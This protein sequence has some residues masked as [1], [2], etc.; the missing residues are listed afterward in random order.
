MEM[1]EI[2]PTEINENFIKLIGAD[3]MLVTAGDIHDFNMMTAS[4]GG[5]GVLWGLPV[6]TA[7]VRPER[8]TKGYIDRT[9]RFTLTFYPESMRK[10]LGVMGKESGRTFDKMHYPGLTP[11]ALSSG[12][13]AFAEA[14]LVIDCEVKYVDSIKPEC[15][16]DKGVLRW[17]GAAQGGYH[18]MY[19]AEIK[20]VYVAQ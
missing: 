2:K 18:D 3:W 6:A 5:V 1:K 7:Y 11:V 8:F 14:R 4:W 15:M 16:L 13:V 12:Q 20:H 19:I 17:Y 10:V 9:G